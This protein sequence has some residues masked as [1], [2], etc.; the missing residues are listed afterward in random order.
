MAEGYTID[1]L[2]A[3]MRAIGVAPGDVLFVH[4]SFKSLGEVDGGAQSV[5]AAF[6]RVLGPA[7][8][9]LMPSFNLTGDRD[10]RAASWEVATTPSTVGWLTEFFRKMPGTFRS[11]HYSHSVAARGIGAE[12]FVADHE[13][14]E[15]FASPWDREPWGRTYGSSSPMIRAYDR[16]GKVLMLGVDYETSTYIHVVEVAF[17][18]ERLAEDPE[19]PFIWLDRPRLGAVWDRQGSLTCGRIGDAECRLFGIRDYVDGLLDVVRADPDAF[20]RVKLGTR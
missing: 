16:G 3:G 8:L 6:E 20:D 18:R 10:A 12:Q 4:A 2:A 17:W 14:D 19:A 7:G 1:D 5:V 11:N 15:G 9:L 13:R